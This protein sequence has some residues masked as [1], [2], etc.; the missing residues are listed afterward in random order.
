[1]FVFC[2]LMGSNVCV[3]VVCF[4]EGGLNHALGLEVFFS[5]SG[6]FMLVVLTRL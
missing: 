1:M 6:C 5:G 3:M 2:L 4:M